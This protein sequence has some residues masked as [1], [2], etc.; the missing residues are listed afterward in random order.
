MAVDRQGNGDIVSNSAVLV[1]K[2]VCLSCF[3][4]LLCGPLRSGV[5]VGAGGVKV[6]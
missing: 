6:K 2:T 5:C 4:V 1:C 3:S